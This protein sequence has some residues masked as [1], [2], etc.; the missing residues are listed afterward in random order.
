MAGH[1]GK[2]FAAM[3]GALAFGWLREGWSALRQRHAGL[4]LFRDPRRK[5]LPLPAA[6]PRIGLVQH[7]A[8]MSL[9]QEQAGLVGQHGD[10][11]GI[12]PAFSGG[13]VMLKQA[14]QFRQAQA[15]ALDGKW[16]AGQRG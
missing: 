5:T 3:H 12:E 2:R 13:G 7:S 6:A 10:A 4:H 15:A 14:S 1:G 16:Q 9:A 8:V 11:G